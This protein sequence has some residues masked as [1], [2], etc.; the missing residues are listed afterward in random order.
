MQ[1]SN[2]MKKLI[3]LAHCLGSYLTKIMSVFLLKVYFT[4]SL[5]Y[6]APGPDSTLIIVNQ[7]D[8]LSVRIGQAYQRARFLPDHHFCSLRTSVENEMNL[9][10]FINEIYQPILNCIGSSL[11][12]IDTLVLTKGI[13]LRVRDDRLGGISFST[14]SLLS[15]AQSTYQNQPIWTA[16]FT[17]YRSC[18]PNSMCCLL[19]TSPSPRD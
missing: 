9:D 2:Y 16:P 18:G 5:V 1:L 14:S 17:E 4:T 19:Y 15:I 10:Q 11:P 12:F 8:E 3:T 6:G 7:N 13:P